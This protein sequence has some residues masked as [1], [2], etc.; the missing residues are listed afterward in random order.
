MVESRGAEGEGRD[1]VEI[2][3]NAFIRFLTEHKTGRAPIAPIKKSMLREHGP[4]PLQ[5]QVQ[6]RRNT[7][8]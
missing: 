3:R 1:T 2:W 4:M 6:Q 5:D 8:K 7:Q